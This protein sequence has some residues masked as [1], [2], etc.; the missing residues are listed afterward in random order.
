MRWSLNQTRFSLSSLKL[1]VNG[2]PIIG[3]T[4][5][6]ISEAVSGELMFGNGPVGLGM[7]IG[8]LQGDIEMGFIPEEDDNLMKSIGS[9]FV[10][11]PIG[12]VASFYE[13]AGSGIYTVSNDAIWIKEGALDAAREG[14]VIKRKFK[15]QNPTNWN[16]CTAIDLAARAQDASSIGGIFEAAGLKL[17]L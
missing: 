5:T 8:T 4:V 7:V 1:S 16:G 9:G 10:E 15:S 17:A 6:T 11:V 3:S 2:V 12:F 13:P 14:A